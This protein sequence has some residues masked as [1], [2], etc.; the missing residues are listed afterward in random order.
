[1]GLWQGTIELDL[2][3]D[4]RFDNHRHVAVLATP[5][6]Q[7]LI[8]DGSDP[9]A[10]SS[11]TY[12][13][14][15][16]LRL[17]ASGET[18]AGSPFVPETIVYDEE[19]R[20]P[21]LDAVDLVVLADVPQLSA[22]DAE[23]V[24]DFV[25]TGGGLLIFS[26]DR[27]TPESARALADAG[28]L[29]GRIGEVRRSRDLPYR[30]QHWNQTHP[31]LAPFA[32]PQYGDL[33]RLAFTAYSPI[34]PETNAVVLA[35]FSQDA[36]AL[37]EKRLGGGRVLWFA[38]GLSHS[39]GDWT[40]NRLFLPLVHQM[41]GD[42]AGLTGGG[43]VRSV[44]LDQ[45]KDEPKRPGVF[46]RDGHWEI[47]NANSRES[48]T[49]RVP[50]DEFARRFEFEIEQAEETTAVARSA[51]GTDN[52]RLDLRADEIWHWVVLIVVAVLFLEVFLANRTTA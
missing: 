13:L 16:A 24:A 19:G 27:T 26:G 35:E 9:A 44:R 51:A 29:P 21:A 14:E 32:D 36:P 31:L 41:L 17:A 25:R 22:A 34:V 28:L 3:D 8:V 12:F 50:L 7:T 11:E 30:W 38:S 1:A 18:Y 5:Q 2:E 45:L 43:P 42:L 23:R 20:L 52:G 40:Q 37:V 15:A 10:G 6:Q 48:E 39:W 49:D 46:R 47:V 33:R 4:L